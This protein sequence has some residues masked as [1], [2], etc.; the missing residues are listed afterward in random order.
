MNGRGAEPCRHVVPVKGWRQLKKSQAHDAS[1]CAAFFHD[2]KKLRRRQA[3]GLGRGD[4][5]GVGVCNRIEIHAH[6]YFEFFRQ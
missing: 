3:I 1:A 5:G 2:G 4:P 6:R